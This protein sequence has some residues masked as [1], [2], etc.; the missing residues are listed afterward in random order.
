MP[1][2]SSGR[3]VKGRDRLVRISLLCGLLLLLGALLQVTLLSEWRIFSTV[4]DLMLVLVVAL[5]FFC[6]MHTGAVCGIAGGFLID[7]L[8]S[9]GLSVLPLFYM[10]VGYIVGHYARAVYPKRFGAFLPYVAIS[11]LCREAVTLTLAAATYREV[12]LPSLL[13][14]SVL[15]EAVL[16]FLWAMLLYFPMK[17]ICQ[18][19]Q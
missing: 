16:T 8:G 9:F 19:L 1:G 5:G 2:F 7:A 18:K 3:P 4:P 11:I 6:G 15:P 12:H 14:R 10:L 17:K 13:L